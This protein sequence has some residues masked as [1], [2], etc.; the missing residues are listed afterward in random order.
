[1]SFIFSGGLFSSVDMFSGT[2]NRG[3]LSR[4]QLEG[5]TMA[6]MMMMVS[7]MVM[8]TMA[9]MMIRTEAMRIPKI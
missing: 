1:M 2:G 5:S 6:M 8:V 7:V 3:E 9:M 4:R